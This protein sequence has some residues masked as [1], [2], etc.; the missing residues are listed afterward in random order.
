MRCS[1]YSSKSLPKACKSGKDIEKCTIDSLGKD[2]FTSLIIGGVLKILAGHILVPLRP[3]SQIMEYYRFTLPNG[4][5]VV[6]LRTAGSPVSHCGLMVNVGTRD[7]EEDEHGM[8]HYIEH[9]LFKG[10][11][12]R[13]PFHILSRLDAVGGELNAYTSKEETCLYA[14]FLNEHFS[15]AIE[16]LKDITFQSTF[17]AREIEKEKDV[18]LDE[19]NSYLDTPSEQIFDDFEGQLFAGHPLGKSILG[20]SESVKSLSQEA[21]LHFVKRYYT[22]SNT[23]FASVGDLTEKQVRK[24]VEKHLGDIPASDT[25]LSR[26]PFENFQPK[27]IVTHRDVYQAHCV[28]GS[29]AYPTDHPDR[30]K[31]ALLNN[32]LGGPG[33]NSRLNLNIREK[34]GFAYNI[35]SGYTPYC[36]TGM[37]HVYLG[38]DQN[39]LK[40]TQKLVMKELRKLRE[41]TLGTAQL[42]SAKQQLK[43][44][45]ALG[46]ES[47]VN[48]M[49]SMAKSVLVKDD[50]NS[51]AE[52]YERIDQI[53]AKSVQDVANEV[54]DE[55]KLTVLTYASSR[56]S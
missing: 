54:L 42:Q 19:I 16:L 33:M 38:T 52:I 9:C 2:R 17:P 3:L 13:K 6:H 46:R 28:I 48:V 7:E 5:R 40:R 36:D 8:A 44:Q 43:G 21:V 51:L 50:L 11:K 49:L 41:K 23:V 37:F 39:Y 45:I 26:M 20:T 25:E 55:D 22:P 56:K 4:L 24:L 30:S 15:R 35:E 12:T 27:Q 34:Y 53:T 10:T 18:I 1:I 32:I 31:M 29:I 14:S 47:K